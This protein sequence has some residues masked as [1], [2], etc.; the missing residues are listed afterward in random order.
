MSKTLF[1][2][3]CGKEVD[4]E[5]A[6]YCPECGCYLK[7]Y[8]D[9]KNNVSDYNDSNTY[10]EN[11]TYPMIIAGQVLAIVSIILINPLMIFS[12]LS[13]IF[14]SIGY[15][16]AKNDN[17]NKQ[18]KRALAMIMLSIASCILFIVLAYTN[19]NK[20]GIQIKLF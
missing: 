14:S 4:I 3:N 17:N 8:I 18:T 10:S 9:A 19:L 6:L 12:I 5:Q 13:L 1:C 11:K 16:Q 7:P 15:Y 20:Y 2:P